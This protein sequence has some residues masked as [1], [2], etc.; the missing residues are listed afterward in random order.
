VEPVES[1]TIPVA[2]LQVGHYI[3]LDLKWFEHPFSFN[4]FKIKSA[5]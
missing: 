3:Y 2:A 4:H 5:V 1:L